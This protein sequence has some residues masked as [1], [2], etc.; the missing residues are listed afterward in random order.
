MNKAGSC[1]QQSIT[2]HITPSHN[3]LNPR[4]G[5]HACSSL[6]L[7]TSNIVFVCTHQLP[8]L[9]FCNTLNM[10][11]LTEMRAWAAGGD[12]AG[13]GL[14]AHKLT[15]AV[16]MGMELLQALDRLQHGLTLHCRWRRGGWLW[17]WWLWLWSWW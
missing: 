6:S 13:I 12:F 4:S 10:Y 17:W 15:E 14:E 8:S 2:T 1:Q 5:T 3:P 16:G 11:V 9:L 7:I